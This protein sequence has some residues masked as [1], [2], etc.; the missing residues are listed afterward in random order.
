MAKVVFTW[1]LG[2]GLGHLVRYRQL[3]GRLCAA[4][5]RVEFLVREPARA[6]AVFGHLP[7]A[8]AAAPHGATAPATRI[9]AANSIPEVLLNSGFADPHAL[10]QR[11]RAWCDL[12]SAAAPTVVIAEYSPTAVLAARALGLRAIAAG[13]GFCLPPPLCPMP[14]LRYWLAADRAGLAQSEARL[15][16]N[17][18][19]ALGAVGARAVG[20]VAEAILTP[21]TFLHAFAEFD[22]VYDR[23]DADYLG[24][25]PDAGFGLEPVWPPGE[26]PRVFAYLD[27][28]VMLSEVLDACA[29][30]GARVCL[31]APGLPPEALT[32]RPRV[33]AMPGPVAL[34]RAAAD[35]DACLSN[36]NV[37]SMMAFLLAGKPQLVVPYT[38][39]KYLVGRRLELLGAGLSA[40][41]RGPG[42]LAGK[43]RAVLTQRGFRRAAAAFASRY[44][45]VDEDHVA[46]AMERRLG[47]GDAPEKHVNAMI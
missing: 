10:G 2:G 25:A 21:E 26:G 4:G 23:P 9:E 8:I 11:L 46:Q 15:L 20:T 3:A 16:A 18:N 7:V 30:V 1:E 36:A 27:P 28:R 12:L 14:P 31:Y 47:L 32:R 43:L 29:A 34:A 19:A 13:N 5:H 17:L 42:D 6:A 37:N 44:A 22:H 33:I 41:L 35:A 40:P 38:L 39:E 45:G 24:V